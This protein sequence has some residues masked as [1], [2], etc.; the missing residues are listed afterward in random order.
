ML[1]ANPGQLVFGRDM[2]LD[3]NF[4]MNYKDIWL[5]NQKLINNN[6]KHENDKQVEYD[7]EVSS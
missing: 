1:Q 4:Q 2:L 6:N 3:I 5:R 7:Y